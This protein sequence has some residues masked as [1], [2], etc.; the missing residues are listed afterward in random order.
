MFKASRNSNIL[1]QGF[2]INKMVDH[3]KMLSVNL[4]PKE[5]FY[6]LMFRI[7]WELGYS[8]V[9]LKMIFKSKWDSLFKAWYYW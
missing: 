8:V 9:N 3:I 4:G 1:I 5:F 2:S 6:A 7:I